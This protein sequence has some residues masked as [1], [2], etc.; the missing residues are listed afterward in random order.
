MKTKHFL[1]RSAFVVSSL[2]AA[3]MFVGCAE[4]YDSPN[5]FDSGVT[6]QTLVTPDSL[7]FAVSA[8]GTTATISWPLVIGADGYL[9]TMKNIDDPD[10]PVV[11]DGYENKMV[12]G[13]QMTASIAEDS[14]YS[15][16]F[17]AIGD[18]KRNNKDGERLDTIFTTLVPSV[19]NIP[20]G[21]DIYEYLQANP[22]D[23]VGGE[24]AIDLAPGGHYTMSG[25]VD[26]Q[27]LNMT[28]RGNK[29]RPAFVE[30]KGNAA[31]YTYSGLK[32]KF[33]RFDM[34]NCTGNGLICMSNTNLPESIK[35]QNLGYERNGTPIGNIYNIL[36]PIY[37]SD[38]WIKN[39]PKALVHDNSVYCAWW[40]LTVTDCIIQMKNTSSTGFISFDRN[41]ACIKYINLNNS[42]IYNIVDN[43]NAYF[44]RYYNQ[45]NSNPQKV[46]G[47][48]N[49]ELSSWYF[50]VSH[51]TLSRCMSGKYWANNINGTGFG[52]Q[53]DHTIFYGLSQPFRR[54]LEKGFSAGTSSMKFNFF[55]N[56]TDPSDNDYTRLVNG[57]PCASLYD[58]LFKGDVNQELDLEKENG[59]V[60]FRPGETVLIE[61]NGG[62]PRWLK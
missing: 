59:G 24:V 50:T 44:L 21:S 32:F 29:A 41:G 14:K 34:T 3:T 7:S 33:L 47:T 55:Y 15:F 37:L 13:C 18:T 10:N 19:A 25:P 51:V 43:S 22:I 45:S 6:N 61:N 5:G 36:D 54:I 40:S 8:D 31:F 35:S 27:Y 28:F 48:A 49:T 20:D 1:C 30:M 11:V 12:D 16:S 56:P 52:C 4:G 62:D 60:D 26:F 17:Q 57:V 58:P 38:V 42:T 9:V 53:F 39:M 46:W 23:S 2:L